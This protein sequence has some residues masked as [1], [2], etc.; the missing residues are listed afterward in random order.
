MKR[1]KR[2]KD[3]SPQQIERPSASHAQLLR[4]RIEEIYGGFELSRRRSDVTQLAASIAKHGLLSPLVVRRN[5]QMG[6]YALIC[7]ARRLT[8]CRLLGFDEVDVLLVDGGEASAVACF[9]EEHWTRIPVSCMDEAQIIARADK[10]EVCAQFA[11]SEATLLRRT[12]LSALGKQ[13]SCLVCEEDLS[14]EQTEP[15]LMIPDENRRME[16]AS[17]IAQ[18]SLSGPQARRL[19]AGAP[20][21]S[22]RPC[23]DAGRNALRMAIQE[24][25][26]VVERLCKRGIDA[27]VSMYSQDNGIG[28]QILL[29]IDE[30]LD[31]G[32]EKNGEK[33]N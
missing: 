3:E 8:A 32:Q 23:E 22:A 26:A 9:L 20:M 17:I 29:K 16:A 14:L 13:V 25:S 24:L 18:R 7:G 1:R 5:A 10:R 21:E 15:L 30:N 27:N 6:R 11:L 19:I 12:R 4:I 33:E 31:N 28:V 2:P